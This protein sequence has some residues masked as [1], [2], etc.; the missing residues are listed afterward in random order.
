VAGFFKNK[1]GNQKMTQDNKNGNKVSSHNRKIRGL[2]GVRLVIKRLSVVFRR[3]L[4]LYPLTDIR[5]NNPFNTGGSL[6]AFHG[7]GLCDYSGFVGFIRK[8]TSAF[9]TLL[10]IGLG[11]RGR[12]CKFY[13]LNLSI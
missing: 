3:E 5:T 7:R 9:L 1:R 2:T 11:Y 8:A 4:V 10:L 13:Y 12:V 6:V